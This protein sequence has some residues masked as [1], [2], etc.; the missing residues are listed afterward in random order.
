MLNIQESPSANIRKSILFN[1]T[2]GLEPWHNQLRHTNR[3]AIKDMHK[4][5]TV[6]GLNLDAEPDEMYCEPSSEGKQSRDSYRQKLVTERTN[7]GGIIFSDICEP[8]RV[9]TWG[10]AKYFVTF[11]GGKSMLICT[12]DQVRNEFKVFKTKIEKQNNVSIKR[13]HTDNGVEYVNIEMK[14]LLES[15]GITYTTTVTYGPQ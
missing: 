4:A 9:A 2:D 14:S 5:G 8:L 7:I 15:E 6:K 3:Q 1:Y 11:I 10:N 13:L 12:K